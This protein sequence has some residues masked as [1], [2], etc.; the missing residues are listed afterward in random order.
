MFFLNKQ[1]NGTGNKNYC[2]STLEAPNLLKLRSLDSLISIS[3]AIRVF[4]Y[5]ELKCFKCYDHKANYHTAR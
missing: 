5:N 1:E 3:Q 4:G 2:G